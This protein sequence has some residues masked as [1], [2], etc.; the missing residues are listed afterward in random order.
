METFQY[1]KLI[2]LNDKE[3]NVPFKICSFDIEASSSHGDFPLP[4]KNYKKLATNIIDIWMFSD[5]KFD[6]KHRPEYVIHIE[7]CMK[8]S[9]FISGHLLRIS[10]SSEN[11]MEEDTQIRLFSCTLYLF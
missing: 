1:D 8:A 11:E 4:I 10:S 2:P 5:M 7:P 9:N 3:D 6:N